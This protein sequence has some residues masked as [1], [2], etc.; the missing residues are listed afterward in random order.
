MM[1]RWTGVLVSVFIALFLCGCAG[2]GGQVVLPDPDVRVINASPD[3]TSLDVL[4][5]DDT[6][7][8]AIAHL[9]SSPDFVTVDPGDHDLILL[10]NGTTLELV[11]EVHGFSLD[12]SYLAIPLGLKDFGSENLKR[13]R[14]LLMEVDRTAPTG[15]KTRL[16]VVHAYNRKPGFLTPSVD[17]QTPGDNPLFKIPG[18]GFGSQTSILID[19]GAQS[20]EVRRAG[21]QSVLV[22]GSFTLDPGKIY[23]C[24]VTG[25]EDEAP[26][27][28]PQIALIE[29]APS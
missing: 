11:S 28:D 9:A 1:V 26:P 18:M 15:N 5:D 19:S 20:F 22:T 12:H 10:E 23:A 27:R 16:V 17:F 25:I 6:I 24:I 2:V 7:A 14:I 29:I 3:T 4:A 13:L 21:T 8:S